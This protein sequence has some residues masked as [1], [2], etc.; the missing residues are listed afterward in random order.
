MPDRIGRGADADDRDRSSESGSVR[1]R[2]EGK[3]MKDE[4][5]IE[6]FARKSRKVAWQR[7]IEAFLC[8]A[9]P[10]D[11]SLD[12]LIWEAAMYDK[13]AD[14]L[15]ELMQY[16]KVGTVSECQDAMERIKKLKEWTS[17]AEQNEKQGEWC[18]RLMRR[19]T[20]VK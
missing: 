4:M 13:F 17:N 20:E 10:D 9:N 18:E 2:A 14:W 12:R 11:G 16:R 8:H 7:N 6:E 3:E 19:F 5:D 1:S 15:E